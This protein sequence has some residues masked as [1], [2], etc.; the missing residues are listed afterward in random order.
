M[1][2]YIINVADGYPT[3]V[4]TPL[5]LREDGLC[6][7]T[8]GITPDAELVAQYS[9]RDSVERLYASIQ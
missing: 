4:N 5:I 8:H 1:P 3:K 2:R 7:V 6:F 9:D